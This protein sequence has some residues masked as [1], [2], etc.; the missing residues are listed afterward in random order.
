MP[1]QKLMVVAVNTP[2]DDADLSL[3]DVRYILLSVQWCVGRCFTGTP[4]R[5]V[6]AAAS[7]ILWPAVPVR[8]VE[9]R[10]V[11]GVG[12]TLAPRTGALG[13]TE[14]LAQRVAAV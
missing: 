10:V 5:G 2:D 8:G 13:S 6:A 12:R 11:W 4:G 3:A 7:R 9:W 1:Q 14:Q